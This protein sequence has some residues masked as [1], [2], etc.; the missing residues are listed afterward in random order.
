MR[1]VLASRFARHA[2]VALLAGSAVASCG[3]NPTPPPR[4][5][6]GPQSEVRRIF[7]PG[8]DQL[9][10]RYVVR[11][12][13]GRARKHGPEEEWYPDGAR[14]TEREFADGEPAGTWRTWFPSSLGGGRES[15]V[16]IRDGVE[17]APMRWW[18]ADGTPHAEGLG[19]AGVRAGEWTYYHENGA[20]AEQ[21]AF[22]AGRRTG[23]WR[24]LYPDGSPRAEGEYE[25][26]RRVGPWKLW[27][28]D[29]ELFENE[30][31]SGVLPAFQNDRDE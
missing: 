4:I 6:P 31:R 3:S 21:G 29:G 1:R 27:D 30:D 13:D 26:G 12:E 23:P 28:E 8:T 18:Y 7:Y 20:I 16:E 14:K 9:K 19:L 22:T 11:I 5:E 17:L 10:K 24:F 25:E 2:L 15:V